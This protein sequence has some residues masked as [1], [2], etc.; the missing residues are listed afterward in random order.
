[1]GPALALQ[2][3]DSAGK[4]TAVSV[5][6]FPVA[7]GVYRRNAFHTCGSMGILLVTAMDRRNGKDASQYCQVV[8]ISP[9][10]TINRHYCICMVILTRS[11]NSPSRAI[12]IYRGKPPIGNDLLRRMS[13]HNFMLKV[14]S[15]YCA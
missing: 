14:R 9:P 15:I 13:T 4:R 11:K 12:A 3:H 7:I 2:W 10:I 8:V 6:A 1:M 5:C